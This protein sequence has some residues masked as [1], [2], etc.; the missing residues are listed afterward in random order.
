MAEG[1]LRRPWVLQWLLIS[2]PAGVPAPSA[3]SRRVDRVFRGNLW[4]RGGPSGGRR[5]LRLWRNRM[6]QAS[7][8]VVEHSDRS[9]WIKYQS[10]HADHDA[11]ARYIRIRRKRKH[12]L[13]RHKHLLESRR[14]KTKTQPQL[15]HTTNCAC[16]P[17]TC[18]LPHCRS[19]RA[20]VC[21]TVECCNHAHGTVNQS[22]G[23]SRWL[24]A[25]W[26]Q[27]GHAGRTPTAHAGLC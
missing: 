19:S 15:A 10:V 5:G 1:T 21:R 25:G 12:S 14:N 26:A 2:R 17:E 7:G 4:T 13:V 9:G 18:P 8:C 3:R 23:W 6:L 20:D 16:P 24:D 27:F 22:A 11:D